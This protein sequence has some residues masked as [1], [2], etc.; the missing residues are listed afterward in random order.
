[1]LKNKPKKTPEEQGTAAHC[2]GKCMQV[3][4]GPHSGPR[5][6]GRG[7]RQGGRV[8]RDDPPQQP[9]SR[10]LLLPHPSLLEAFFYVF[11]YFKLHI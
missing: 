11:P 1:M 3:P 4:A 7:S 6:G 10:L 9:D 5:G 8:T 2:Q